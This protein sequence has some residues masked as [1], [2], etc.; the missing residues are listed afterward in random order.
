MSCFLHLNL[1]LGLAADQ[2]AA[3]LTISSG[4]M[5]LQEPAWVVPMPSLA[6]LT[7]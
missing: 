3:V 6:H 4:T 2:C 5:C 1:I 7:I